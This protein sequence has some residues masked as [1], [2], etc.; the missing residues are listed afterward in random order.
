MASTI[1]PLS[2]A[3]ANPA[4]MACLVFP[5]HMGQR[6][7]QAGEWR[8]RSLASVCCLGSVS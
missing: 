5:R 7:Q 8:V 6:E 3:W 1:P 2:Y 4:E